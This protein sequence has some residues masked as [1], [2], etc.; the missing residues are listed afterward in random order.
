MNKVPKKKIKDLLQ[1]RMEISEYLTL[2][3]APPSTCQDTEEDEEPPR[4][5]N[6][7]APIPGEDVRLDGYHHWPRVID[8]KAPLSCR[9]KDCTSRSKVMCTKC[10][11]FLIL[12]KGK[13]CFEDY[14]QVK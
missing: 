2:A 13:T 14:H 5:K 9:H 6:T 10:K 7:P 4:K 3:A 8:L 12:S 11:I 1:F